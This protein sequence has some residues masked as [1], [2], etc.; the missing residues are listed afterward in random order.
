MRAGPATY[1]SDLSTDCESPELELF[2]SQH[3]AVAGESNDLARCLRA[4]GL[5]E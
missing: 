5:R 2:V 4:E 3:G 1:H